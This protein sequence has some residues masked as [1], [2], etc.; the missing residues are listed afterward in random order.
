VV[1][2]L[3]KLCN[4]LG[5]QIGEDEVRK[6]HESFCHECLSQTKVAAGNPAITED[7]KKQF[8]RSVVDMVKSF[9]YEA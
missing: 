8:I 1:D 9:L 3:T 4:S 5:Q 7:E 6:I 2:L